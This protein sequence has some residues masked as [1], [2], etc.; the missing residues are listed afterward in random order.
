MPDH[1]QRLRMEVDFITILA[2]FVPG[3]VASDYVRPGVL[4]DI[5][6][7]GSMGALVGSY[8][9]VVS[10]D[11]KLFRLGVR[12]AP[13]IGGGTLYAL[14]RIKYPPQTAI[15]GALVG[16]LLGY[17]MYSKGP[18]VNG[19]FATPPGSVPSSAGPVFTDAPTPARGDS[20]GRF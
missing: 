19:V 3:A 10:E 16:F 2:N 1:N 9:F 14:M 5:V 20:L 13:Y 8:H 4:N 17:Y 6:V 18:F 7:W 15:F 11:E 12:T